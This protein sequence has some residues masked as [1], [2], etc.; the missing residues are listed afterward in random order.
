MDTL[1]LANHENL[2]LLLF[3]KPYRSHYGKTITATRGW[4]TKPRRHYASKKKLDS[5][6]SNFDKKVFTSPNDMKFVSQNLW[7]FLYF[8]TNSL[9]PGKSK[10]RRVD[11]RVWY[12]YNKNTLHNSW[13]IRNTNQWNDKEEKNIP[14]EKLGL[15]RPSSV[16]T[17]LNTTKAHW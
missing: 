11:K 8:E 6:P 1:S 13:R 4:L 2:N 3:R 14:E 7:P 9:F 10:F 17:I 15:V 16:C 12:K 5:I